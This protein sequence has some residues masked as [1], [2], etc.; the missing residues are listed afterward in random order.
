MTGVIRIG[1]ALALC[2]LPRVAH[3]NDACAD[4]AKA[5][6]KT[7]DAAL[8]PPTDKKA[9]A[10]TKVGNQHHRDAKKFD[11]VLKHE[12]AAKEYEAAI[13]AYIAAALIDSAP[14]LLYNLGQ[15]YRASGQYEKAIAQY[16]LF[17]D[18]G[19][20]GAALR[21]LVECHIASM[22]SELER[23]AASAPPDRKSVV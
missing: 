21:A 1:F 5:I 18:R 13:E 15:T 6:G 3:G 22:T 10:H 12:E 8:A 9:A 4:E 7:K 20:P 19:R 17:L 11:A 16:Q 14:S 23:A 2:V